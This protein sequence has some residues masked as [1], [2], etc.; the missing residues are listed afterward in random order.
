MRLG[1]IEGH[2]ALLEQLCNTGYIVSGGGVAGPWTE[3]LGTILMS[4]PLGEEQEQQ[5]EKY[6]TTLTHPHAGADAAAQSVSTAS[7]TRPALDVHLDLLRVEYRRRAE[8]LTAALAEHDLKVAVTPTGGFF[9]FVKLPSG[10]S[11]DALARTA[12]SEHGV[13]VLP[14]MRCCAGEAG[15]CP[16]LDGWVRLCFAWLNDE[17]LRE[18]AARLGAAVR[19]VETAAIQGAGETGGALVRNPSASEVAD[20]ATAPQK[21]QSDS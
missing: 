5:D 3:Q 6:T 14:G 20:A 8:T 13:G 16:D 18:G 12:A 11:A 1:W 17:D 2:P 15:T 4:D 7:S 19:A 10:V 9:C 21:A